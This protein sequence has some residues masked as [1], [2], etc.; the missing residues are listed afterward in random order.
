MVISERQKLKRDNRFLYYMPPLEKHIADLCHHETARLTE[1]GNMAIFLAFAIIKK[2]SSRKIILAPDQGRWYSYTTYPSFFGMETISVKTQDGIIDISDLKEKAL[3]AAALII[4]SF[5]GYYAEQ[6][7]QEAAEV[8]HQQGCFLIED[9]SGA[10]GD[11]TLCNG[12]FSDI[13]IGSFGTWKVVECGYG[14]W[15]SVKKK[16]FFDLINTEDTLRKVHSNFHHELETA[17]R[18]N[19]L[20]I[21]LKLQEKVKNDL[22]SYT[23]IHREKRG[24]NVITNYSQYIIAYC[25]KEQYP[26]LLCPKSHRITRE[27]ISIEL[28][29]LSYKEIEKKL[30]A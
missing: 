16:G 14:G 9:A 10:I 1:S 30:K 22:R 5:A 21:L 2:L 23:I 3:T 17:L 25:Q 11:F 28:K 26:F 7:L 27:A 4:P 18:E 24:L 6:P 8:C 19:K 29:R 13:I 15:I 12:M 20:L